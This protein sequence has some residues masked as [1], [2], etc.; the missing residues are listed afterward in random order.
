MNSVS[1]LA[2]A[3]R[4]KL[5]ETSAF[6]FDLTSC[7]CVCSSFSRDEP[8]TIPFCVPY[9][10]FP[11]P[12]R[13]LWC[14]AKTPSPTLEARYCGEARRLLKTPRPRFSSALMVGVAA[15]LYTV[16]FSAGSSFAPANEV[17]PPR[18]LAAGVTLL[19]RV[20]SMAT[21]DLA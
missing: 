2:R 4:G 10:C 8:V 11:L 18:G 16:A 14:S 17:S 1:L 3:F 15:A 19:A 7:A 20:V 13:R 21:A 9:F 5:E 6:L 12:S